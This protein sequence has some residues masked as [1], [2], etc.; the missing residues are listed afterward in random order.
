MILVAACCYLLFFSL[1]EKLIFTSQNL[2]ASMLTLSLSR[3]AIKLGFYILVV[4]LPL[5]FLDVLFTRWDFKKQ[6]MM[7]PREVKDEYKKKEGDPQIKSKRKEV[8]KELAKKLVA[9]SKVKD[10]DIVIN[11]PTHIA[12]AVKFEPDTMIAP[13]VVA[14]GRG[15]LGKYIRRIAVKYSLMQ[16]TNISLA[17]RLYKE[18][19]IGQPLPAEYFDEFAPIYRKILGMDT[20]EL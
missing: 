5:V 14:S 16:I 17:R 12:V 15:I 3:E 2:I 6:M 1:I 8:Q 4:T 9:L 7:S 19:G 20:T 18:V 11:N 10:A 13:I